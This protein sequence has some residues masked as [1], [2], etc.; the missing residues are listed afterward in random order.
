MLF[1]LFSLELSFLI[2]ANVYAELTNSILDKARNLNDPAADVQLTLSPD[3]GL[4]HFATAR[5]Q[6]HFGQMLSGS[7]FGTMKVMRFSQVLGSTALTPSEMSQVL[8]DHFN[9]SHAVPP[10]GESQRYR[11]FWSDLELVRDCRYLGDL[12]CSLLV[13]HMVTESGICT[14]FNA[15]DP[16]L[17]FQNILDSHHAEYGAQFTQQPSE[18]E[19]AYYFLMT[20]RF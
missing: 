18:V 7:V 16:S 2:S 15:I 20:T 13:S 10:V 6:N 12:D 5:E 14:V 1:C 17:V 3:I 8:G 4:E 11:G 9:W 19:R